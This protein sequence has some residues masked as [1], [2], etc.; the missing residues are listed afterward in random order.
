MKCYNLTSTRPVKSPDNAIS[1]IFKTFSKSE[2][3]PYFSRW[4]KSLLFASSY[5]KVDSIARIQS[6]QGTSGELRIFPT[7]LTI[8]RVTRTL[9][10]FIIQVLE[11]K[12][13]KVL[14]ENIIQGKHFTSNRNIIEIHYPSSRGKH[15]PSS[16]GKDFSKILSFIWWKWP[17]DY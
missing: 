2:E 9:S 7:F 10:K 5:L 14:E 15:Y 1:N 12:I 4:L 16:R 17:C 8:I 6:G 3:W 13:I 11:E